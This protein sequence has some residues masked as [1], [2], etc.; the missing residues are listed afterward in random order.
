MAGLGRV[1]NSIQRKPHP[2]KIRRRPL[3]RLPRL[4]S[5]LATPELALEVSWG[6]QDVLGYV[7]AWSA[8]LAARPA[9]GEA[10]MEDFAA[11]LEAAWP[12]ELGRLTV[13]WPPALRVGRVG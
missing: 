7:G 12:E 8:M 5:P 10:P 13:R 3:S 6:R 11:A 2:R 1:R 9:L 4:A